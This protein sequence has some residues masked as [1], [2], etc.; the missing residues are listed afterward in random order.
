[1]N[2][3]LDTDEEDYLGKITF[4]PLEIKISRKARENKDRWRFTIA[5]E[6]GHLILHSKLLKERIC[7]KQDTEQTLFGYYTTN[8]NSKRLELQSNLFASN[9]LLPEH[10]LHN[11]VS[12]LFQK[13]R[14]HRNQLY[15]DRQKVNQQEVYGILRELSDLHEISIET[16]K[17]RLIQSGLLVDETDMRLETILRQFKW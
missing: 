4:N 14:I 13:Y 9:L 15:L 6:I 5:H 12:R 1:M 10:I 17:I 11:S 3:Y 2:F 16:I 7:E 8:N